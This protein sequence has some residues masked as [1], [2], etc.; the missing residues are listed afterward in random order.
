MIIG[1]PG[2]SLIIGMVLLATLDLM[3]G[4][5]AQEI[6][7]APRIHHQFPPDVLVV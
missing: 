4:H 3:D 1:S 6:V 7:A 5:S 2:G